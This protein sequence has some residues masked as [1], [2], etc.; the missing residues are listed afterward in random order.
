MRGE[1]RDSVFKVSRPA[2]IKLINRTNATIVQH[3]ATTK[4]YA[5]AN[6]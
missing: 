3:L 2:R 1:S 6:L 5:Y 4:N